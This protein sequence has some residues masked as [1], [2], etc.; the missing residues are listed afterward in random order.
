VRGWL[1]SYARWR[2][3]PHPWSWAMGSSTSARLRCCSRWSLAVNDP[4][5]FPLIA[6]A[7][8]RQWP[9]IRHGGRCS[10]VPCSRL[11]RHERSFF[12]EE[13]SLSQQ[14]PQTQLAKCVTSPIRPRGRYRHERSKRIR[15]ERLGR[16]THPWLRERNGRSPAQPAGS[17]LSGS[18]LPQALIQPRRPLTNER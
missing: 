6:N 10:Q 16:P 7:C 17:F 15:R 12:N 1:P 14:T 11:M 2:N 4:G 3:C 8:F 13:G 9:T 18:I 5:R